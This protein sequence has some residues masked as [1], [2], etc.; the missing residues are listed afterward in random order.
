MQH[1]RRK[2][3][4]HRHGHH[5]KYV[6]TAELTYFLLQQ[7]HWKLSH[8]RGLKF[9]PSEHCRGCNNDRWINQVCQGNPCLLQYFCHFFAILRCTISHYGFY[10]LLHLLNLSK[11]LNTTRVKLTFLTNVID[12]ED[13]CPSMI[14]FIDTQSNII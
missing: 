2:P 9:P 12:K 7:H 13:I 8:K 10:R 4:L 5:V 6:H 3:N 14:S 1:L 11:T